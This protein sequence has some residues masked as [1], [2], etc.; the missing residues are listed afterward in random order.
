[1]DQNQPGGKAPLFA[2][3]QQL[4]QET[5]A[6]PPL[7]LER[8]K[9]LAQLVKWIQ[10]SG[11]LWK[12]AVPHYEDAL[13]QTW[14]YVCRNLCEAATGAAYDAEKGTIITWIN[15]YLKRRLQDLRIEGFQQQKTR[16]QAYRT[17]EG[18]VYD[19][20]DDLPAPSPI[21]P[22][23]EEI[24]DWVKTDAGG[25][26]RRIHM[27]D[28]PD[29]NCQVLILRRLPPE[30]SWKDLGQEFNMDKNTLSRFYSRQCLPQLREFAQSQGYF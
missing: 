15:A 25:K 16:V 26:L 22:V 29:V 23:L 24:H 11:K 20:I 3:L 17:F 13:Q 21:P 6:Q 27:R 5:C 1:M 9:G 30:T 7:S 19:P 4:I 28:R 18:E 10:H 8:Q 12:E 2:K 14:F